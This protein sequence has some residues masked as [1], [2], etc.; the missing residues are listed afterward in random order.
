MENPTI[1]VI[2]D[3][4][5]LDDHFRH[6]WAMPRAVA[7]TGRFRQQIVRICGSYFARIRWRV[8]TTS[9]NSFPIDGEDQHP[10]LS[11]AEQSRDADE[12][13]P[14]PVRPYL[15]GSARTCAKRCQQGIVHRFHGHA[16]RAGRCEYSLGFWRLHQ[17]LRHRTGC[18]GRSHGAYLLRKPVGQNHARR[19]PTT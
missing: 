1:V 2:T 15:T 10:L 17:H 9:T 7:T 5:D 8:F 4:N 16:D 19:D 11:I 18:E 12:A 14:Q 3:R 6:F 13:P